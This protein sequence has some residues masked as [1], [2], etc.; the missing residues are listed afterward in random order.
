MNPQTI[1]QI[2]GDMFKSSPVSVETMGTQRNCKRKKMWSMLSVSD[3]SDIEPHVVTVHIKGEDSS[4][5]VALIGKGV[6]FDSGGINIKTA[7]LEDM[8]F[9]MSGSAAVLAAAYYFSKVKPKCD[10]ISVGLSENM[11]NGPIF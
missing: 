2:V 5:K 6:T 3:G 11:I 7:M 8:K 9:D 4:K 1:P 10:V